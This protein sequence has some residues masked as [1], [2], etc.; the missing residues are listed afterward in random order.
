VADE[1]GRTPNVGWG[2]KIAIVLLFVICAVLGVTAS[3]LAFRLARLEERVGTDVDDSSWGGGRRADDEA[4]ARIELPENPSDDEARRY[5]RELREASQAQTIWSRDDP[6]VAKLADLGPE[7]IDLLLEALGN[8]TIA[9]YHLI[10]AL[11]VLVR[12][13]HKDLVLDQLL[14]TPALA[15]IVVNAGWTEDAAELFMEGLAARPQYLPTEWVLAAAEVAKPGDYPDL[16]HYLTHGSNP[17]YMYEAIRDL[18]GIELEAAILGAWQRVSLSDF[19]Q[20]ERDSL[21]P[22][23]IEWGRTDALECCIRLLKEG[24][25]YE[26]MSVREAL[27]T[28]TEATGRNRDLIDWYEENEDRL[29]WD[30][31]TRK[32]R[33][34]VE[35]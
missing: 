8:E 32:F 24:Q 2:W 15:E 5:I 4:I 20:W 31:A 27:L 22:H 30:E 1:A 29:V 21:A 11:Q 26:K 13:E 7:R 12:D 33:V 6:Q 3:Q 28:H 10:Y 14:E 34:A 23:V 35:E 18:P 19:Y 17:A 16:L 25:D 9:D